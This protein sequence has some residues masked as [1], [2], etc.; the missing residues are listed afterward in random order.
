MSIDLAAGCEIFP[1]ACSAGESCSYRSYSLSCDACGA[2]TVSP[3]GVECTRCTP[4]KQPDSTNAV[5]ADCPSN[6]VST[7]GI[8]NICWQGKPNSIQ[9]ACELCVAGTQL[10]YAGD[11]CVACPSGRYSTSSSASW[12]DMNTTDPN[13]ASAC[14]ACEPGQVVIGVIYNAT[15]LSGGST[16]GSSGC[17]LCTAGKYVMGNGQTTCLDCDAGQYSSAGV[18]HC[19]SCEQ[20]KEAP[21][22]GSITC[23]SCAAG[24]YIAIDAT[25]CTNCLAGKF[26]AAES[27]SCIQCDQGKQ[28]PSNGSIACTPCVA[29]Q[30]A[31]DYATAR[32]TGCSAGRY[33]A[34]EAFEC[35]SCPTR[36]TPNPTQ[37]ECTACP[38]GKTTISSSN[39]EFA[40]G[41]CE[42][43]ASG[44]F[45]VLRS[46]GE[47][48]CRSCGELTLP[49]QASSTSASPM[50]D[51]AICPNRDR[52]PNRSSVCPLP[53]L[54]LHFMSDVDLPQVLACENM[55]SC[56]PADKTCL[57]WQNAGN[58]L[59]TTNGA[60][61]A[62]L[63]T[64]FRCAT[65]VEGAVKIKGKCTEV[66]HTPLHIWL[67]LAS[68][69]TL[70][71]LL[72]AC[73]SSMCLTLAIFH[74]SALV[75]P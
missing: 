14:L 25:T 9:S 16:G 73:E 58:A 74:C 11:S 56:E 1:N 44:Y 17:K 19:I 45:G 5:C 66:C 65:C 70:L 43:C 53:G 26:S 21:T 54:W 51:Q 62:S 72:S 33:S 15:A 22:S 31:P 40:P 42:F 24:Q 36:Q 46:D 47:M 64:G 57:D 39:H 2:G 41:L 71:L 13:Y 35:T 27:P 59:N 7:L 50:S 18:A 60:Q 68:A 34:A 20:G 30:Y 69:C 37:T 55:H 52:T 63:H 10:N 67:R 28:A 32:C 3:L 49:K 38:A 12:P 61:C 29:G 23:T 6:Q 75:Y 8:C 4:G 48:K